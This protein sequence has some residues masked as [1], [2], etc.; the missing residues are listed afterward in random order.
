M[1]VEG[2]VAVEI[3]LDEVRSEAFQAWAQISSG[4][5]LLRYGC[6]LKVLW[7]L[8]CHAFAFIYDVDFEVI[9]DLRY[10][11]VVLLGEVARGVLFGLSL[12]LMG[13]QHSLP[14]LG[15]LDLANEPVASSPLAKLYRS[16][17]LKPAFS[18]ATAYSRSVNEDLH[19]S[20]V[21]DEGHVLPLIPLAGPGVAAIVGVKT[22]VESM[23]SHGQMEAPIAGPL[24][25]SENCV[26]ATSTP[27]AVN[28][29]RCGEPMSGESERMR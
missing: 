10:E 19:R 26:V 25:R 16:V 22:Q 20:I 14:D 9:S 18:G 28:P 8:P 4:P 1:S 15:L 21:K 29:G 7:D 17:S 27:G 12:D 24:I 13:A 6:H 3:L 5:A 11:L 2:D 23:L